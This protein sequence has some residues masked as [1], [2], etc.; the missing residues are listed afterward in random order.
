MYSWRDEAVILTAI[1]VN[2][3]HLFA[4]V[5]CSGYDGFKSADKP[6]RHNVRILYTLLI[7]LCLLR[8]KQYPRVHT[9]LQAQARGQNE[10]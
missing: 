10:K 5:C 7:L 3:I 1:E 4:H 2:S 9:F 8:V 6:L